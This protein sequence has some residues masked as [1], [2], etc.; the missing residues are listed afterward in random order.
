MT[1]DSLCRVR[2]N[3]LWDYFRFIV[4]VDLRPKYSLV[5]ESFYAK[6][7][8]AATSPQLYGRVHIISAIHSPYE[9]K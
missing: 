2:L 1:C 7:D 8:K 4:F 3:A 6:F 5:C 9:R